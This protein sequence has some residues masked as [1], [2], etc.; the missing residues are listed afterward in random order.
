[1]VQVI[2]INNITFGLREQDDTTSAKP[3]NHISKNTLM[4]S[5]YY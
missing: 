2:I 3:V 1:M 4:Y 5:W